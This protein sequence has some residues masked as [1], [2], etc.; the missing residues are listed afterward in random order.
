MLTADCCQGETATGG[1]SEDSSDEDSS[2]AAACVATAADSP[3]TLV[4]VVTAPAPELLA[5]SE[6]LV[7]ARRSG[8]APALSRAIV[9]V[10]S[11]SNVASVITASGNAPS[12]GWALRAWPDPLDSV[13]LV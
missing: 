7:L 1:A 5:T 10:K 9:S 6:V 4:R 3:P 8:S 13:R 2:D 12:R 11:T